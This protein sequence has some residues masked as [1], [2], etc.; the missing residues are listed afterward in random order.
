MVTQELAIFA[1]LPQIV[2]L[3]GERGPVGINILSVHILQM[4]GREIST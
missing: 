2:K 3:G 4:A 1:N